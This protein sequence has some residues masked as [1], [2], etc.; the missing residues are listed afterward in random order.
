[1][2][3]ICAVYSSLFPETGGLVGRAAPCISKVEL[4]PAWEVFVSANDLFNATLAGGGRRL[5][6]RGQTKR[7]DTRHDSWWFHSRICRRLQG[8]R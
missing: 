4:A 2:I 1:M 7:L 6:T 5:R 8:W 3:G